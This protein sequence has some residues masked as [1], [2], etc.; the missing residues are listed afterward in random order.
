[1]Y[2][3]EGQYDLIVTVIVIVF[4]LKYTGLSTKDETSETTVIQNLY[5][6]FPHIH[7][8]KSCLE[9]G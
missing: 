9:W 3:H 8:E 5:C 2:V 1:M 4:F 7:K 6:L